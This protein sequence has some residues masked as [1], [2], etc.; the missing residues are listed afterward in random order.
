M[1][2]LSLA[3]TAVGLASVLYQTANKIRWSK[4]VQS[5]RTE[6]E[7][8]EIAEAVTRVISLLKIVRERQFSPN[9]RVD[10]PAAILLAQTL[11][12]SHGAFERVEV[13]LESRPEE[14]SK[15]RRISIKAAWAVHSRQKIKESLT[16]LNDL[17]D[18]LG[19]LLI[20]EDLFHAT[21]Q[22]TR[23]RDTQ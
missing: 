16:E 19:R 18:T 20:H 12:R 22:A 5:A 11:E 21:Q 1:D 3:A 9:Y 8:N 2:P 17:V 13:L 6:K 14:A 4:V 10:S 15:K 7:L 23:V